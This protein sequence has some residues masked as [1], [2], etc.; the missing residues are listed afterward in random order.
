MVENFVYTQL[1]SSKKD[2][3]SIYYWGT[4]S[5]EIDFIIKDDFTSHIYG[6]EVKQQKTDNISKTI[7]SF[8]R[9]Y[10]DRLEKFII[11]TSE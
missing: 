10:K 8:I 11:T 5:G 6:I 7:S 9:H 1:C 4:G 2:I 3:E